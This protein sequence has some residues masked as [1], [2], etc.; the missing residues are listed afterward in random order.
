MTWRIALNASDETSQATNTAIRRPQRESRIHVYT[1]T[2]VALAIISVAGIATVSVTNIRALDLVSQAEGDVKEL[3]D[4]KERLN[5]E[6]D[7]LNTRFLSMAADRQQ[8][9]QFDSNLSAVKKELE[10]STNELTDSKKQLAE[11]DA[12]LIGVIRQTDDTQLR[13]AELHR[14]ES[15]LREQ[16]GLLTQ[17]IQKLQTDRQTAATKADSGI[18]QLRNRISELQQATIQLTSLEQEIRQKQQQEA[19]LA[20]QVSKLNSLLGG[21]RGN[22]QNAEGQLAI[23]QANIESSNVEREEASK[24][25]V[26]ARGGATV[27]ERKLQQ[28]ANEVKFQEETVIRLE[29]EAANLQRLGNTLEQQ[30][31][32]AEAAALAAKESNEQAQ[33]E[34]AYSLAQLNSEQGKLN[35]LIENLTGV[36]ERLAV[37]RA[38]NAKFTSENRL[39]EQQIAALNSAIMSAEMNRSVLQSELT[40]LQSKMDGE[41]SRSES[42]QLRNAAAAGQLGSQQQTFAALTQETEMI[43]QGIARR[44]AE[45]NSL[46]DAINRRSKQLGELQG[47]LTELRAQVA[48]ESELLDAR[49]E[50]IR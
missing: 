4:Q 43:A 31:R 27:A 30:R 24:R 3:T 21:Q 6:I 40:E 37:L 9:R 44:K 33:A 35:T 8:L 41:R 11:A 34:L 15:A 19:E 22:I 1:W 50:S 39:L 17:A 32:I 29:T 2:F 46:T 10:K 5:T 20:Q 49:R 25:L 12:R 45:A 38:T 48:A 14:N 36:T 47:Q 16:N 23:V 28:L 42:L 26:A 7:E 18:Q 13:L